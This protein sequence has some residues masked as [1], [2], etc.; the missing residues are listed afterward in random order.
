ML[1]LTSGN[2]AQRY[3]GDLVSF[4]GER[5]TVTANYPRHGYLLMREKR[6]TADRSAQSR[7][8]RYAALEG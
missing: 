6:S 1:K 3:I 8:V 7:R 2:C 5:Y 4:R